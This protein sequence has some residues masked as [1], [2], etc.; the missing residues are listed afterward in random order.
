MSERLII[1]LVSAVAVALFAF[2]LW[3]VLRS[4]HVRWRVQKIHKHHRPVAYWIEVGACGLGLVLFAALLVWTL[5][6]GTA[7]A[8]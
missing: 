1:L 3:F 8:G 5:I 2:Q 6:R 4:G 7:G